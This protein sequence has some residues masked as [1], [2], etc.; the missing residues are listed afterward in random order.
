M[1]AST[2]F[3]PAHQGVQLADHG[4]HVVLLRPAFPGRLNGVQDVVQDPLSGFET[5]FFDER[6]QVLDAERATIAPDALEDPVGEE[7]Q[8]VAP[9]ERMLRVG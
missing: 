8:N 9:L 1:G 4:G 6:E 2:T 7:D 3:P 5:M